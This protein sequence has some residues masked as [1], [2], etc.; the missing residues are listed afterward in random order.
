MN[1]I[2]NAKNTENTGFKNLKAKIRIMINAKVPIM[3]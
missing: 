2:T 3:N 1:G